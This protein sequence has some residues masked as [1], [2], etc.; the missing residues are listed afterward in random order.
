M[1]ESVLVVGDIIAD[2]SATMPAYPHEGGE[3]VLERLSWGSGGAGINTASGLAQLGATAY[4]LGRVG[5]DSVGQQ[6]L[7]AARNS[8]VRLDLVQRDAERSTGIVFAAVSPGGERTFFSYRGANVA[9]D[10]PPPAPLLADCALVHVSAYTL[11]DDPQRATV[12]QTM[13]LAHSGNIP[14]TL[15]LGPPVV[16]RHAPLLR[17]LMPRLAAL[18][19]NHDELALLLPHLTQQDG[20]AQLLEWGVPLV[21]LKCGPSGCVVATRDEQVSLPALDVTAR[22]ATGCGDA[23]VAGFVWGRLRG[24]K[25]A[26]CAALGNLMGGLTATRYGSA[27]AL[28][29]RAQLHAAAQRERH[30]VYATAATLLAET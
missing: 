13:A 19:L 17:N 7:A 2:V 27:D 6:A 14:V 1:S 22:D 26:T 29:T 12:L 15:D 20:V 25:L 11:L 30:A 16:Q 9:L 18:F 23:F 10:A 8:G 5:S 3:V 24:A 4:L 21:A 28:P